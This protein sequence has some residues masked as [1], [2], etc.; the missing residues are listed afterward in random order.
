M[1]AHAGTLFFDGRPTVDAIVTL[2]DYVE[3][4]SSG[5]ASVYAG[6]GIA[7]ACGAT[8]VWSDTAS[9][10]Q[11]AASQAGCVATWDGRLDNRDDLLARLADWRIRNVSDATIALAVFERWGSDGFRALVGEWSMAVWDSASRMLH[12]ARDYMG[13]RP[14]YYC[15]GSESVMWSSSLAELV[16]RSGRRAGISEAFVAGFMTL[17]FS[18]EVTPYEGIRAVPT[19]TCVS[20]TPARTET[21]RRF[22]RMEP[23]VVRFNDPRTYEEQL[24]ELWLEAVGARLRADGTAWAELSGGLDSSSVVCAADVLIRHGRVAARAVQPVSYVTL[25]S[26][27]GDERRFIAEVEA[28]IGVRSEIIGVEDHQDVTDDEWSWVTPFAVQGAGLGCVRRVR[29]RGGQVILSGRMGDAAMGCQPDNSVAVFDDAAD[30]KVLTALAGIREWSR[31]CRTPYFVIAAAL[32]RAGLQAGV[33]GGREPAVAGAG[34][35]LLTP[36]L[37]EQTFQDDRELARTLA[38]TRPSKREMVR[39]LLGYA[40]VG[41]FDL[42]V[43]PPGVT[44]SYPFTHRPLVEYMLAIPGLQLSAPGETRSLMRRAFRGMVPDRILGRLSKGYYPP[45]ALRAVKPQAASMLPVE[46]LEVVRRGWIEPRRLE[47]AIRALVD[48]GVDTGA[49]IRF[50]LR[51]EH[52]IVSRDRRGPAAIPLGKEVN[53]NAVLNA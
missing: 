15:S 9:S 27:E 33:G 48:G 13:V 26:P 21:R 4:A 42:P 1:T 16:D 19:A 24:R 12:L 40:L 52:W 22:W 6:A 39:L 8:S 11:L 43:Q 41:R 34:R 47:A 31:A 53:T 10:R 29:E 45:S 37:R 46:R 35:D 36:R 3:A 51:L 44:Y 49:G 5:G 32:A 20:F 18:T 28:Q 7:M 17:Q 38:G 2:R 30:G 25:R 14:L 50:V 23:G